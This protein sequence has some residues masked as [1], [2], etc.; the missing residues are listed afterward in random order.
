[1]TS[2]MTFHYHVS[3]LF[4]IIHQQC[5]YNLCRQSLLASCFRSQCA[6]VTSV[7]KFTFLNALAI[8]SYSLNTRGYVP[9]HT[10][11]SN[12][13]IFSVCRDNLA[14]KCN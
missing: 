1:M 9:L 12:L 7:T 11:C 8:M 4:I 3:L 13:S 2:L 14:F 6:N 10:H 5:S